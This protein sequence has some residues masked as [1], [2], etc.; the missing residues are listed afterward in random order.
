MKVSFSHPLKIHAYI[1]FLPFTNILELG[2][3]ISYL[4]RGARVSLYLI[5]TQGWGLQGS[6]I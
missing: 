1:L 2:H 6:G 5:I 3:F 4:Y